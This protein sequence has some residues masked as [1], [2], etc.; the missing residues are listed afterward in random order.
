MISELP[1]K[2]SMKKIGEIGDVIGGGTPSTK[3]DAYYGGDVSWITP[4]DLSNHNF[5]FIEKGNKNIT[6]LGLEKSSARL[7]PEGTVL[8]S[9]RA[10]IGYV[11]IAKNELSTNQG[12][13]SVIC[14]ERIVNNKFIY[15]SLK[16]YKDAIESVA[17][18]STFKEVSGKVLKEFEIPI[19]PLEEQD[20]IAK[21]LFSI[22]QKIELNQKMNQNLEETGKTI[23]KHWFVHFEFP[24]E[25]GK[26]YK[27]SGGEM[28]DSELGKIPN[29]WGVGSIHEICDVIYG[30]PFSSK[31][32]NEIGEGIALIRIRDLKKSR[33]SFFT[34]EEHPKGTLIHP[35]DIIAGMDAEFRP[36]FWLGNISWMNQRI[37]MFAPKYDYI[38]KFFI[39]QTVKAPLKF[40]ENSK[41]GTTVIHLSKSDIDRFEVLIPPKNIQKEFHDFIDP[42][43]QKMIL[44]AHEINNLTQIRDSILPKLIS[45]KIRVP[46]EEK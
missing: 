7:M 2:W 44:N 20:K 14:D 38:P 23:F 36:Y 27:S 30:A 45:G 34:T 4:K 11:A 10:P 8:F 18:G 37:C 25:E 9:S 29:G 5:M 42:I 22:D 46:L 41:V 39:Y 13:K 1:S 33:S 19:P 16:F 15:Y 43:F 12:F 35:G 17:S 26:P 28:V 3:N 40:Y 31:F 24:N 21:I 6:K 32:F